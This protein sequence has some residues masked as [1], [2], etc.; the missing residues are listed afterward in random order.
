MNQSFENHARFVPAFHFFILPVFLLNIFCSIYRLIQSFS[1]ES[2]SR[3]SAVTR[4]KSFVSM[5]A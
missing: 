3:T 2:A 4:I 5:W 1:I